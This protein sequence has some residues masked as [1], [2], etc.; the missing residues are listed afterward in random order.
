VLDLNGGQVIN[1]TAS[2]SDA[3]GTGIAYLH[4][5]EVGAVPTA[6]HPE[7]DDSI[8]YQRWDCLAGV[9]A[10]FTPPVTT[11]YRF[12]FHVHTNEYG[13]GDA[14]S[15]PTLTGI[16]HFNYTLKVTTDTDNPTTPPT[17][18]PEPT[19]EV[20]ANPNTPEATAN[21]NPEATPDP[22]NPNAPEGTSEPNT[23][24]TAEPTQAAPSIATPAPVVLQ[25]EMA[26]DSRLNFKMGD[27]TAVVYRNRDNQGAAALVIYGVNAQSRGYFL[28][29]VTNED[30]VKFDGKNPTQNTL[31]KACGENVKVYV[32]TSGEIQVNI[33]VQNKIFVTVF[34]SLAADVIQHLLLE[35]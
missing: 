3:S 2:C 15:C 27:L 35:A 21:P 11:Q 14:E 34:D 9:N 31:I 25:P 10:S 13:C 33:T 5:V 16:S 22:S 20:T 23:E 29:S 30:L 17:I 18:P 4:Y 7:Y 32:L 28:C 8:Y 6:Q 19:A 12:I 26:R 24:A 1:I